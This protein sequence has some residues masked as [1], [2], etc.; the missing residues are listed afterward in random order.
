MASSVALGVIIGF[1]RIS[2]GICGIDDGGGYSEK[3]GI[4][5]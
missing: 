3:N 5:V 2:H 4:D 1:R